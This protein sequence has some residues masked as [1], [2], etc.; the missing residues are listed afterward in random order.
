[1]NRKF[2][3]SQKQRPNRNQLIVYSAL[4]VAVVG[5]VSLALNYYSRSST[6]DGVTSSEPYPVQEGPYPNQDRPKNEIQLTDFSDPTNDCMIAF[7][8]GNSAFMGVYGFSIDIP[9]IP[10]NLA[11]EVR[12]NNGYKVIAGT[13]DSGPDGGARDYAKAYNVFLITLTKQ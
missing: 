6:G 5:I 4:M 2:I 13:S 10:K 12:R 11:E 1:M 3:A 8:K 7:K 9:G